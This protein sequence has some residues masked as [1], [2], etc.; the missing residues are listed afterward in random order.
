MPKR[1]EVVFGKVEISI[2]TENVTEIN[3]EVRSYT[4]AFRHAEI[5]SGTNPCIRYAIVKISET[6]SCFT[7]F[8]LI[9]RKC[10]NVFVSLQDK[11]QDGRMVVNLSNYHIHR[12]SNVGSKAH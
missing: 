11:H 1:R 6:S 3:E 9:K 12:H 2:K 4:K 8:N 7:I 10:S 5:H